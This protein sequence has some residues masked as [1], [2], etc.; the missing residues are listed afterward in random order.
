MTRTTRCRDPCERPVNDSAVPSSCMG[1]P[2]SRRGSFVHLCF[3]PSTL[4][5][6]HVQTL[7]PIRPAHFYDTMASRRVGCVPLDEQVELLRKENNTLKRE[8]EVLARAH[9]ANIEL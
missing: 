8:N 2:S 6:P 3:V 7:Q 4:W 1:V 9:E 5:R